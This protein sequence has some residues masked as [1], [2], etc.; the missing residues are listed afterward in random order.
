MR[1]KATG[2]AT[3]QF[4]LGFNVVE[5]SVVVLL[6]GT[7]LLNNVDYTVDYIVGQ[8]IIRNPAALVPGANLSIKFEQNDLFSAR[9]EAASRIAGDVAPDTDN[10]AGSR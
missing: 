8:I 10:A 5:G 3:S 6:N 7:P 4:S 1:G 2:D 9:L